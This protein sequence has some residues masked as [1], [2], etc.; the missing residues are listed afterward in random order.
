MNS[1][2][3]CLRLLS[4]AV[5]LFVMAGNAVADS[6]PKRVV[7][8]L[9]SRGWLPMEMMVDNA[10]AGIAVDVFKAVMPSGITADVEPF[11]RPRRLLYSSQDGVY[12]RLT[13]R[14]WL[15]DT[16]QYLF[17]D[18]VMS[19]YDRMYSSVHTPLEYTGPESIEGKTIGCIKNYSYPKIEPMMAAGRAFRYDVNRTHVLLRMVKEGRVDGVVMDAREAA[20]TIRN[21][22]GLESSDFHISTRPVDQVELRFVFNPVP[23]WETYLPEINAR[24]KALREGGELDRI[25]SRYK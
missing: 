9:F 8:A 11:T 18:P 3:C 7:F 6:G 4:V 14:E 25:L 24:I 2:D 5:M 17:S 19:I 16:H 23:G 13:A 1:R 15:N 10:P 20:W 12:T 22:D 21:T